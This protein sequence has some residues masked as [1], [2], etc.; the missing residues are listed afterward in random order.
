MEDGLKTSRDGYTPRPDYEQTLAGY[1][2]LLES[3]LPEPELKDRIRGVLGLYQPKLFRAVMRSG[4]ADG[5]HQIKGLIG[6]GLEPTEF[7]LRLIA[8]TVAND[9]DFVAVLEHELA[10]RPAE[11]N[12]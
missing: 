3:A 6:P 5:A 2:A 9:G 10:S 4:A 7:F 8:A 11:Y 1:A 12:P